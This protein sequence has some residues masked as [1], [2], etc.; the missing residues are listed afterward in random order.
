MFFMVC[1][2][3]LFANLCK[4]FLSSDSVVPFSNN[5]LLTFCILFS[6]SFPATSPALAVGRR[7]TAIR[8]LGLSFD[9]F[10]YRQFSLLFRKAV[11]YKSGSNFQLHTHTYA[12]SPTH[13]HSKLLLVCGTGLLPW[14]WATICCALPHSFGY[15]CDCRLFP[16][17]TFFSAQPSCNGIFPFGFEI[18]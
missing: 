15:K 17:S 11:Q 7:F 3:L 1:T 10:V 13:L 12:H 9:L 14:L 18:G 5:A 4:S 6:N 16:E 2:P 8:H